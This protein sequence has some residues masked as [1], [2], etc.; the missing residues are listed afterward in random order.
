MRM[1][2]WLLR[3]YFSD[4]FTGLHAAGS[5]LAIFL[6]VPM[7]GL[8]VRE[9]V[10]EV[11]ELSLSSALPPCMELEELNNFGKIQLPSFSSWKN[12]TPTAL[13][14]INGMIVIADI[15]I[16]LTRCRAQQIY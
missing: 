11:R 12:N 8:C 4:K 13:D 5:A 9:G 3:P 14:F 6:Q 15:Q 1:P 7:R 10:F 2:A 16:V